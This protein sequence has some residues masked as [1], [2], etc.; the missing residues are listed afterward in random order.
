MGSVRSSMALCVVLLVGTVAAVPGAVAAQE[1][2]TTLT[3]TVVDQEGN[4]LSNIDISATWDDGDGGPVNET[5][6]SNGQALIDVAEGADVSLQISDDAY[7]RNTPYI[8][9]D[10][11]GQSVEVT[12]SQAAQATVTVNNADGN[13]VENARVRLQRDGIFVTSQVT[14][15]D[16]TVTTPQIEEGEYRVIVTKDGYFRN[17]TRETISGE[18]DVAMNVEQ[19]S[20]LLRVTVVD[21]HFDDPRPVEGVSV[22][23]PSVGTL[24]SQSDGQVTTSVPVNT[25]YDLELSKEGYGTVEQTV[26]VRESDEEVQIAIQREPEVNMIS[27]NQRVVV[28]ETVRLEV[29]DEYGEPV[30]GAT[31]S[32]DD[33]D[34]GTTNAEG[35]A[36]VEVPTEGN[37]TYTA[38]SE[39]GLLATTTVE[40]V[41]PGADGQTA[42]GTESD[43]DEFDLP[44]GEDGPGFTPVT[45]VVAVALFAVFALRRR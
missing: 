20:V 10:A 3:V 16:G 22:A 14:G 24:Q 41:A 38:T 32:I 42:S 30:E 33:N 5:T 17:T 26:E 12:V 19:G 25:G 45:V 15:A 34:L 11:S 44:I 7:V 13:A 6:R 21:D 4:T 31:I 8:V 35:V 2:Q 39:D 1:E 29:T 9:E 18:T 40:G 27:S 36:N 28:G 37:V 23:V 43:G